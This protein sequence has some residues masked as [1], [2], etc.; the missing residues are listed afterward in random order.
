MKGSPWR[1]VSLSL[2]GA[3]WTPALVTRNA[4]GSSRLPL[5]DQRRGNASLCS[6]KNLGYHATSGNTNHCGFPTHR[7]LTLD[8][9]DLRTK[10]FTMKDSRL[11]LARE[12]L[13]QAVLPN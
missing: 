3:H 6:S 9:N 12:G 5:P 7:C 4:G 13:Y 1:Q 8:R 10:P 11:L 2:A